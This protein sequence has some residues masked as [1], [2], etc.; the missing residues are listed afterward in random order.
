MIPPPTDSSGLTT[1]E[2]QAHFPISSCGFQQPTYTTLDFHLM[3]THC[4]TCLQPQRLSTK[5]PCSLKWEKSAPPAPMADEGAPKE[6]QHGSISFAPGCQSPTRGSCLWVIPVL[7]T[8]QYR[9]MPIYITANPSG[10]VTLSSW[11]NPHTTQTLLCAPE[12]QRGLGSQ[13]WGA[14]HPI[15]GTRAAHWTIFS[16]DERVKFR[17]WLQTHS[18]DCFE[19][20]EEN[21]YSSEFSH[22]F[23]NDLC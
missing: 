16:G 15:P 4:L 8:Q 13:C 6:T 12:N 2:R 23:L 14:A 5:T 9:L 11:H 21:K 19:D 10:L 20:W 18:P 22:C 1:V 3:L 7:S 17:N